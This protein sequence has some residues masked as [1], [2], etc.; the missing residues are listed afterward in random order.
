MKPKR[1][2]KPKGILMPIGGGED[3]E[4][5]FDRI[6]KE[7]GKKRPKICYMTVATTSPKEAAQKHKKFFDDMGMKNVTIIHFDSRKDAD[8]TN[9]LIK[10]KECNA[11]FLGGGDQLRLS[12]LLGGT[13]FLSLMKKRYNEDS[14]FLICGNSAGAAAMSNTMIISGSSEDALIKGELELTNGLDLISNVF[15]DTHFTERGRFGRLIQTLT[16]NPG[17]LGLGLSLDTGVVIYGGDELEVIGT[18]LV[19]IADGTAI[20]Y[21]D[22]TEIENGDPI[23]VE[24]IKMHVLG[25]G[26]RFS[27][28]ER[29]LLF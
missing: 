25:P 20:Q 18:G 28:N 1:I 7:T 19:V 2:N 4:Q 21:S 24:G 16:Y 27:I 13:K 23:T 5:I 26:K 6:I 14:K 15:I 22:L 12:S 3:S 10:L 8:L 29:K 11:I 9:N 17:V